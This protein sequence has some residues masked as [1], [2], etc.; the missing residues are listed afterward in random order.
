MKDQ[1]SFNFEKQN[2][3]NKEASEKD[4]VPYNYEAEQYVLGNLLSNNNNLNLVA[5]ILKP[6]HFYS[7]LHQKIYRTIFNFFEKGLLATPVTLKSI[8]QKDTQLQEAGG[9]DYLSK[10]AILAGSIIDVKDYAQ[11][12]VD[13]ALKRNLIGVGEEMIIHA[14]DHNPELSAIRQIEMAEQKLFDLSASGNT[15][16]DFEK[17]SI[18]VGTAIESA[19]KASKTGGFAAI[20]SDLTDLDNLLSGFHNSDLLILAGRPSMGKTALAINLALNVCKFFANEEVESKKDMRAVGF[21]SLEMSSEQLASRMLAMESGVNASKFRSG[22]MSEHDFSAILQAQTMLHNMP[23][24]IDDTPAISI[25]AIRTR[26]RRLK[27][28]HNLGFLVIDYL[29]LVNPSGLNRRENRV[30]ELSEITQGLKALAKEL[31]M[32]I[33]ALSQLSRAVEHREDKRPQLSDLRESGTIEQDSDIVMFIFREQYYAEREKPREDDSEKM[34][35][36]K[37]RMEQVVNKAE[38]IIGKQRHGPV[39]RVS[40][41]FD[42]NTTKFSNLS[43]TSYED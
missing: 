42:P 6:E 40:L 3:I 14:R 20:P 26:A 36:W 37:Q 25:S 34:A 28:K 41:Y 39:G 24:F 1:E 19:E 11:L 18:S 21:F 8:L 27:R 29:Q 33:I 31:D 13:L 30:L 43:Q 2:I 16:A 10:L 4:H 7:P 12:I 23:F 38:V 5:E 9:S 17:L 15:Q 32:P 22:N 35:K